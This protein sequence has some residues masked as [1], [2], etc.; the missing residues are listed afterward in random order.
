MIYVVIYFTLFYA[1]QFPKLF[2]TCRAK[3][4][5]IRLNSPYFG[6]TAF[7]NET[8]FSTYVLKNFF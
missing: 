3:I 6:Y 5:T 7:Y 1:L 4:L 8:T 2:P